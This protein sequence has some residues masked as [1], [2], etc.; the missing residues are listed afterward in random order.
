MQTNKEVPLHMDDW[1]AVG[2]L[3]NITAHSFSRLKT[4]FSP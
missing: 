3:K 1:E 2:R 4:L